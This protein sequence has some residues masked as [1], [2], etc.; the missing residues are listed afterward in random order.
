LSHSSSTAEKLKTCFSLLKA[1][2]LILNYVILWG[3]I[4]RQIM[5]SLPSKRFSGNCW[6]LHIM[7][8]IPMQLS[9]GVHL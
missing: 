1:K 2:C 9:G 8:M 7:K 6:S 4:I 5:I 3:A